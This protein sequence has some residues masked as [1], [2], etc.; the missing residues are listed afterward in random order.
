LLVPES[1]KRK[2]KRG[3]A[4]TAEEGQIGFHVD[5]KSVVETTAGK[6]WYK[7]SEA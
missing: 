6:P 4:E 7:N 3:R 5:R 1:R 2:K